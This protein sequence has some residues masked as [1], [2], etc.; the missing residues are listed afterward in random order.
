MKSALFK[1]KDKDLK[2]LPTVATELNNY[3]EVNYNNTNY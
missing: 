2:A 3:F 1:L